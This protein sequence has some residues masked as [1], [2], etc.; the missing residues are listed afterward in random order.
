MNKPNKPLS[1]LA[2]C[3]AL[4]C[5]PAAAIDL[6]EAQQLIGAERAAQAYTLLEP[7][8]F[9]E[10]GNPAFDYLL[11]LAALN[12]GHPEQATLIFERVLAVDPRFAA[13]RVDMGRAYFA[14]GD[15]ERAR[16]EFVRAA[17]QHPPA[18]ALDTIRRHLAAIGLAESA[19][20]IR[21]SGYVEIGGGRD[22]N[23][24]NATDQSQILVPAL[25]SSLFTLNPANVKTADSYLGVA[26]G[27]EVQYPIGAAWSLYGGADLHNRYDRNYGAFNYAALDGRAGAS[28][29]GGAEQ[30]R[31]GVVLGRFYL[32][33]KNNRE[34][35]G[36]NGEWRHAFDAANQAV[37][38]SQYVRYR[39]PDPLLR[40]SNFNQTIGGAGWAHATT[41][42]SA[43][44]FASVY[45]GIERDTD[46][47]ADG[48]KRLRGLRISGQIAINERIDLFAAAGTQRGEYD[49]INS[50]FQVYRE[51]RQSDLTLGLV[52]RHD[53]DWTLRP[54][55]GM[56]ANRSNITVNQYDRVDV[57]LMLRREF[58]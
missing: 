35:A 51:D 2:L 45:A 23:V 56:I 42:G 37:L 27:G 41:D 3:V 48:G 17:Q 40:T 24:N 38:F 15:L 54:Q 7:H 11:G 34:S 1:A 26:A 53:A 6:G 44:L 58:K 36:L 29:S 57:S 39:Y 30:I 12:S 4:A 13:A 22:N 47:R 52:Y 46:L 18:A 8:E 55:I 19:P 21:A 32:A 10:A 50:A 20:G 33:D 31:G 43:A 16:A 25:V 5:H 14:L 49:R 9:A 28:Y